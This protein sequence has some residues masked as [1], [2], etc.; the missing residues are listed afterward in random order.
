MVPQAS[1][2][3][4]P[5]KRPRLGPRESV[6]PSTEGSGVTPPAQA[7]TAKQE[8]TFKGLVVK[9]TIDMNTSGATGVEVTRG[10]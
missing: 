2:P 5:Y 9:S 7:R 6:D 4:S 1:S 8:A 10:E 3:L